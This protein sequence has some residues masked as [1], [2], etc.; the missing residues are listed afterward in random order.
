MRKKRGSQSVS[1]SAQ[2]IQCQD[3]VESKTEG[4]QIPK[5]KSCFSV[6]DTL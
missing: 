5:Y 4:L 3:K 1:L 6:K 2:A